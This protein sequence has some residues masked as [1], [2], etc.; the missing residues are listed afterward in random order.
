MAVILSCGPTSTQK[1]GRNV[2]PDA[3]KLEN[4]R[5][6][7]WTSNIDRIPNTRVFISPTGVYVFNNESARRNVKEAIEH[8][9][10]ARGYKKADSPADTSG[11]LISFYVLEQADSLPTHE[12]YLTVE[13]TPTMEATPATDVQWTPVEAGTLIV[14]LIDNKSDKVVW[15]GFASGILKPE[16]I[17]DKAK[18]RQAVS[19]IFSRYPY[20]A[21][22]AGTE[23]S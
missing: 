19:S 20:R 4:V 15:Q 8:E 7:A 3:A 21:E 6:Y 5:T 9:M 11:M 18:I 2:D 12:G 10:D 16:D 1:I 23:G 17:N 22:G 13:G 14:N